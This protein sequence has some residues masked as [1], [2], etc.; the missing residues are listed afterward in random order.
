MM[1]PP[2]AKAYKSEV[3]NRTCD[4]ILLPSQS[5]RRASRAPG[6]PSS[7]RSPPFGYQ[8]IVRAVRN[9]YP[10]FPKFGG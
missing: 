6:N 3:T 8:L 2:I 9:E 1:I 7:L 4:A 10:A 5:A